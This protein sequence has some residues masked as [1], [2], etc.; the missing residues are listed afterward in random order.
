MMLEIII[1]T[2]KERSWLKLCTIYGIDKWDLIDKIQKPVYSSPNFIDSIYTVDTRHCL[3]CGV[4]FDLKAQLGSYFVKKKCKCKT[5][6]PPRVLSKEKL[7][8][9]HSAEIADKIIDDVLNNRKS[10]FTNR[11]DYWIEQGYSVEDATKQVHDIQ[12]SRSSRSASTKK[13]ARGFSTRTVEYWIKKGYTDEDAI[14]KVKEVQT[15]NGIDVYIKKYG[16]DDGTNRFND[17]I[18]RWQQKMV[19]MSVGISKVSMELFT[20]V[21]PDK[22]G[23]YGEN[24][25]TVYANSKTYRVD[26][27]DKQHKKIIEFHGFYWHADPEKYKPTDY[28]RKKLASDIWRND[29]NKKTEL[30]NAGFDV[31]IIRE[32][33]YYKNKELIIQK[34]KDF[35]G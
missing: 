26:Y 7:M 9:F 18:S 29:D 31:L 14:T 34:C 8:C 28:I 23:L 19:K 16:I 5:E 20:A 11:L 12:Q 17:R 13:G 27:Y 6:L 33:E 21:D 32:T 15:T 3:Y 25:T 10:G 30:E 35:L 22:N 2:K 4:K 24:E 1:K